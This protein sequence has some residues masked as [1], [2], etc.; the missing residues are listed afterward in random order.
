MR[1]LTSEPKRLPHLRPLPAGDDLELFRERLARELVAESV[2][3]ARVLDMLLAGTEVA[4]NA[5]QHGGGIREVRVGRAHARFVC[6]VTDGG[7]G[8][9]DPAAGYIAP[10][11]GTG[12]GL[13][14]ARQLTWAL[15]SFRS[16]RG[17]TVRLWM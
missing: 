15:E 3:E 7:A 13:W 10:R 11:E 8:F 9:D 12:K 2:P 5:V 17:F 4:A 16:P 1:E 6:E 14:V